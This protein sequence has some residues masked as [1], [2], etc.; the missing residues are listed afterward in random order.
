MLAGFAVGGGLSLG[1]AAFQALFRNPL[2]DP[3]ILGVSAGAS[4]GF[5]AAALAGVA[6]TFAGMSGGSLAA[7]AGAL[8]A[9]GAVYGFSRLRRDFSPA[10]LLLA[11][12]AVNF[13]FSSLTLL[14]QYLGDPNN[15]T[16]LLRALAGGIPAASWRTLLLSLPFILPGGLLIAAQRR[17]LDIVSCGEDLAL[18]RGVE[19]GRVRRRLFLGVS[20]MVG[21]I[22]ALCGPIG[23]VGLMAPHMARMLVGP[24]HR[25][26]LPASAL[27]G[28]AFLALADAVS[29]TVVAPAEL[30]AGVITSLCGGPFFLWLLLR[31]RG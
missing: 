12:V 19:V 27:F 2:A 9:V 29:R 14:F 1:G 31:M 24:A 30:P 16:R 10:T 20:L 15:V 5:S 6:A 18:S 11:G 25:F 23:F 13:F 28:G 22:T 3:F 26:L 4:A 8:V 21:G 7:F 17:E